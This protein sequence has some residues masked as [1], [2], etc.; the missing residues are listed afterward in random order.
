MGYHTDFYGAFSVTP[1]LNSEHRAYLEAFATIRHMKRNTNLL[2]DSPDPVRKAVGLP[3][4]VEGGFYVGSTEDYGQRQTPD[5]LNYNSPSSDQPGLWCQWTP[6]PS[7]DLIEWDGGEK[8]YEYIRWIHYLIDNFL[9]P[10]GYK[11]N[12]AVEWHGEER[13]DTGRIFIADNKVLIQN[14]TITWDDD[15]DPDDEEGDH[16]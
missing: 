4:G 16:S 3:L 13:D 12:G 1:T 14:A 9:K 11:L 10:W 5:I 8:F 15:Y 6:N 2:A 7:G